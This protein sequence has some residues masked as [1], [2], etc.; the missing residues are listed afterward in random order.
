MQSRRELW[1]L[2]MKAAYVP[3]NDNSEWGT[4]HAI[5]YGVA[6][7]TVPGRDSIF[8]FYNIVAVCF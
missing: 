5:K 8:D 1:N 3:D 4:L 6:A 2:K 7:G